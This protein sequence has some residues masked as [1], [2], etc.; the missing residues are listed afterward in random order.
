MALLHNDTEKLQYVL[1]NIPIS[2]ES[3]MVNGIPALGIALFW[4]KGLKMLVQ[5]CLDLGLAIQNSGAL[6]ICLEQKNWVHRGSSSI[7]YH[8]SPFPES[9][10]ILLDFK[11]T[12][13]ENELYYATEF[14]SPPLTHILLEHLR[15]W[16]KKLEV[17]ARR[18]PP[19]ELDEFGFTDCSV[20]DAV[21]PEVI[22]KLEARG[23]Y[24]SR[25]FNLSRHDYRLSPPSSST[26]GSSSIYHTIGLPETA[27]VAFDLGFKDIDARYRGITPVMEPLLDWDYSVWLIY[28]GVDISAI[29][30]W[31]KPRYSHGPPATITEQPHHTIAHIL[32]WRMG[33]SALSLGRRGMGITSRLRSVRAGDG[34]DC[35]CMEGLIGCTPTQ[36][37]IAHMQV[38]CDKLTSR[39]QAKF[40]HRVYHHLVSEANHEADYDSRH[41]IAFSIL[42]FL[43]FQKL[44]LRHTCC[45][46]L[47]TGWFWFFI[48][49][50]NYK[51]IL[52]DF[53]FIREEDAQLREEFEQLVTEL[54]EEFSSGSYT[55]LRFIEG[56][57]TKRIAQYEEEKKA[58]RLTQAE[59]DNIRA[60][61]V[62]LDYDENT[63][64]ETKKAALKLVHREYSLRRAVEQSIRALDYIW[65]ED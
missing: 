2:M 22:N 15:H 50:A 28:H 16:R 26:R 51:P 47:D 49:G 18:L 20:L 46:V 10:K 42:R 8:D 65:T 25:E 7:I 64:E 61:G 11:F 58:I 52:E 31:D 54:Q 59:R 60:L 13:H 24:P 5:R 44:G 63:G 43:T 17:L 37:F 57:W 41:N 14:Y 19:S 38:D 53:P 6:S 27:Q 32:M 39:E 45:S 12:L 29:A 62:K 4:P 33:R 3:I 55:L 56:F 36:I 35:P 21:A 40:W 48:P 23:I 30:S 9:L 1:Q 34:C